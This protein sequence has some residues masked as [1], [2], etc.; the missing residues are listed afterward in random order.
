MMRNQQ[1]CHP[2]LVHSDSHPVAGHTRLRYFK[3]R[4][5]NSITVA[6]AHLTV[7]QTLDR[8]VFSELPEGKVGAPQLLLP[9][10]VGIHLVDED[11]SVY[12]AVA[13]E[14]ALAITI[15][16]EPPHL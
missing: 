13:G 3:Q 14:V 1:R 2:R 6:D 4:A 10:S 8:E 12:T 11:R 9:V 16:V 7:R 5:A 15:D